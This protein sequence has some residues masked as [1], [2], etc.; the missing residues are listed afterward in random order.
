MSFVDALPVELITSILSEYTCSVSDVARFR[1]ASRECN[2]IGVAVYPHTQRLL[3]R[4]KQKRPRSGEDVEGVEEVSGLVTRVL[5]CGGMGSSRDAVEG[6]RSGALPN[7]DPADS[8]TGVS[9]A[10]ERQSNEQDDQRAIDD[11]QLRAGSGEGHVGTGV[12]GHGQDDD[13]SRVR[14]ALAVEA[15]DV[16]GVQQGARRGIGT[17]V[18]GLSER[19]GDHHSRAGAEGVR[20]DLRVSVRPPQRSH[21]EESACVSTLSPRRY[22]TRTGTRTSLHVHE[23]RHDGRGQ[24]LQ[25]AH[26][27]LRAPPDRSAAGVVGASV[28]QPRP[29]ARHVPEGVPTAR[30]PGADPSRKLVRGASARRGAGLHGLHSGHRSAARGHD[31]PLRGRRVPEDLRVPPREGPV[32]LR[33]SP[34]AVAE[35]HNAL[36]ERVLPLRL[37]L[38]VRHQ[39]VHSAQVQRAG[40]VLGVPREVQHLRANAD[41][42]AHLARH[43]GAV[44][45]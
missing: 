7:R 17:Q 23:G 30:R 25:H 31:P 1:C 3:R 43:G 40:R 45:L 29:H 44:P 22:R 9:V 10:V 15:D 13:A 14:P 26:D 12:R 6:K 5:E 27:R 37:R 41:G 2:R 34:R 19:T 35:P 8:Q 18:Q 42:A 28:R 20:T 36:P 16:S 21:P 33:G 24:V 39:H 11:R 38:D 4:R 32:P